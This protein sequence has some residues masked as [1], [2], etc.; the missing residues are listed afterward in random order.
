MLHTVAWVLVRLLPA[1]L[2]RLTMCSARLRGLRTIFELRRR[3]RSAASAPLSSGT[4][5]VL[6]LAISAASLAKAEAALQ[7]LPLPPPLFAYQGQRAHSGRHDE[8]RIALPAMRGLERLL[9]MVRHI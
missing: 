2:P 7:P 4:D 9:T 8:Q 5:C 3:G 1:D 6:E